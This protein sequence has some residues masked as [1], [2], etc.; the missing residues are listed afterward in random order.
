MVGEDGVIGSLVCEI[1]GNYDENTE[2]V[3]K[4]D[5]VLKDLHKKTYNN[6]K[7]ENIRKLIK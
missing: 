7:L 4:L 6:Y 5:V 1:S 3:D 2:L